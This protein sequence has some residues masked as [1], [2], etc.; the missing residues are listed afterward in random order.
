MAD[1]PNVRLTLPNRPE[2]VLL[3]RQ[4]LSGLADF[5]GLDPLALNDIHTAVTEACNNVVLHAY[6]GG[7]GPLEV[8]VHVSGSSL[9]TVV[10]D[11]GSGIRPRAQASELADGGIGLPV[12]RALADR[13]EIRHLDGRGTEVEMEFATPHAVSIAPIIEDGLSLTEITRSELGDTTSL[14]IAPIPL[15]RSVLPRLLCSLAARANFSVDRISDTQLLADTLLANL[16]G[17][18]D[19][20]HLGFEIGTAPHELELHM[21]PLHSGSAGTLIETCAVDGL[22]PLMDRLTDGHRVADAGTSELLA[23]RLI[24]RRRPPRALGRSGDVGTA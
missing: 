22:G 23:L 3:V 19:A 15:A 8:E 7:E 11:H 24:E 16:D 21:G 18:V 4:T 12:I 9:E 13:V 10:R 2:N 17:S 20:S 5:L 14:A 1:T 6:G